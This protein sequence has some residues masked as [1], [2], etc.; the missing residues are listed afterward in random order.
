MLTQP[1]P[2]PAQ[3]S[4][5]MACSV[6]CLGQQ[7]IIVELVGWA[8]SLFAG[9]TN[10]LLEVFQTVAGVDAKGKDVVYKKKEGYG[11]MDLIVN[12]LA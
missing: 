4:L 2:S 12:L 8:S 3:L 6:G 7:A 11:R 5:T 1:T 10:P 9:N